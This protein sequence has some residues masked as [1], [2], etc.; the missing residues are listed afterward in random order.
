MKLFG[1]LKPKKLNISLPSFSLSPKTSLSLHIT[2]DF[3]RILEVDKE[4]VPTFEPIE[5]NLFGKKEEE[6]L[7]M[8]KDNVLKL[9]LKGRV[10]HTCI[11]A[12]NGILKVHKFPATLSK[13]DLQEAIETFI[14]VEKENIKE[15]SI[16][17]YYIWDSQDKKF[18]IITLVIVRKLFFDNLKK[19]I[20]GAGL[21]LGIVDYEV[22]TIVNGGFLFNLRKPFAILYVD[23]HE[24]VFV[25]YTGQ[26]IVYNLSNFSLKEYLETKEDLLLKEF[27]EEVN[28]LLLV[29][30]VNALYL[31]G[32][33][34]E[35]DELLEKLLSNLPILSPLEPS[36]MTA[37]FFVSY[38]LCIRGIE[39]K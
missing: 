34:I 28:N 32:K 11:T 26:S 12:K 37:S 24:S 16:Y 7:E 10:A 31:A 14:R 3:L 15:D 29:N 17:D 1:K 25:Y 33:A 19:L 6:K 36:H 13:K 35:Y 27:F 22:S 39:G 9:G 20:E 2:P 4:G 8:L 5:I 18:K 38:A 30:E 23:L 21:K